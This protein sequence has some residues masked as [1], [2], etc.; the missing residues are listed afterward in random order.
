[1]SSIQS[2]RQEMA[3]HAPLICRKLLPKG[4]QVKTHWRVGGLGGE[5]GQSLSISLEKGL[6][7]DMATGEGGNILDLWL[8]VTGQDIREAL[9]QIRSFLPATRPNHKFTTNMKMTKT[10]WPEFVYSDKGCYNLAALRGLPLDAVRMAHA[11][12]FVRFA[13]LQNKTGKLPVWVML[14]DDEETQFAQ[15]R[16]LDGESFNCGK[17]WNLPGSTGNFLFRDKG[18]YTILVEG[19]PD[20][21]AAFAVD[22]EASIAALMGSGN[23][24]SKA[25]V[26]RV[27]GG[28]RK[29]CIIAQAD[30]AGLAAAARWQSQIVE[31][32][33]PCSIICIGNL[34]IPG[35][36]DLND[37][38]RAW[39][40][41]IVELNDQMNVRQVRAVQND[42]EDAEYIVKDCPF[43]AF[44]DAHKSKYV[45]K[46]PNG[47]WISVNASDFKLRLK[48]NGVSDASDRGEAS[49]CDMVTLQVQDDA[50]V[51]FSGK[52]SGHKP[53]YYDNNGVRYVVTEAPQLPSPQAGEWPTLKAVIEGL[54]SHDPIQPHIFHSWIKT[55][56]SSLRSGEQQAQQALAIVGPSDCGKS[57][58][59]SLIT[60]MLTGREAKAAPFMT[61]KT[62][63]N[64]DLF[65]AEHLVLDD[66]FGSAKLQD[67]LALAANIKTMCVSTR[68]QPCLGKFA[69]TVPLRPWWRISMTLNDAPEAL[70]VLPPLDDH[71][72]D[73]III[74][75]AERFPLPMPTETAEDKAEF[76]RTL[77]DEIPAYLHWLLQYEIPEELSDR[78]YCV[79]SYKDRQILASLDEIAPEINLKS[80]IDIGFWEQELCFGGE[81]ETT[82]AKIK[83]RLLESTVRSEA[84]ELLHFPGSTKAYLMRL[85]DKFPSSFEHLSGDKFRLVRPK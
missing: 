38:V 66:E 46:K 3:E 51:A 84:K 18:D 56:V 59:Q 47:D 50:E 4:K 73:K 39:P 64:A 80:L 57:L 71:I 14:D 31:I 40:E 1:M 67:R 68:T 32:G 78:R 49:P 43:P 42:R 12:G 16:R 22:P 15:A 65:E 72:E 70:R 81:T 8:K 34:C 5:P 62:T 69:K 74:L 2:L 26:R 13:M 48:C 60:E 21:L 75:R 54:F 11:E 23:N 17:T 52:V 55:A 9:P 7:K 85:C 45:C 58:L 83:A 20:F 29:V 27:A 6:W 36:G 19:G 28:K 41:R 44:F 25:Q 61:G 77:T 33:V 37:V 30:E 79:M 82:A 35:C 53:G 76:W 24:L 10:S 63:F